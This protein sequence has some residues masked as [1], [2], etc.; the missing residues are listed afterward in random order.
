MNTGNAETIFT[1]ARLAETGHFTKE[2]WNIITRSSEVGRNMFV[3]SLDLAHRDAYNDALVM[4]EKT[5]GFEDTD[6][7]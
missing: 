7:V 3:H 2:D 4:L 6:A 5:L 1:S